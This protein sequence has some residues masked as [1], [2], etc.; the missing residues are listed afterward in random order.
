MKK[1][2]DRVS[3]VKT[4]QPRLCSLEELHSFSFACRTKR[5]VFFINIETVH[6]AVSPNLAQTVWRN[7]SLNNMHDKQTL[8]LLPIAAHSAAAA[9]P[10][11]FIT[12]SVL[13]ESANRLIWLHCYPFMLASAPKNCMRRLTKAIY[14]FVMVALHR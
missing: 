12:R 7:E 1:L 3:R 2:I 8:P 14:R 6:D 5:T 11:S 10:F 13:Y 9:Q 4:M